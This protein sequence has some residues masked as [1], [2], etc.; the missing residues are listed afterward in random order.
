MPPLP[1]TSSLM[2]PSFRLPSS[3]SSFYRDTMFA[4]SRSLAKIPNVEWIE[5]ERAMFAHCPKTDES[6]VLTEKGQDAVLAL[7]IFFLDSGCSARC[8]DHV[9]PYLID[10]E[11]SLVA[12]TLQPRTNHKEQSEC[13]R[14]S[15]ICLRP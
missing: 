10:V 8:A 5:V 11:G 9:V 15:S 6:L 13:V 7:G 12:A 3:S 2:S 1:S 4:L 14:T